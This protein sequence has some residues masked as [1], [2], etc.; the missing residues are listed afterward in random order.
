MNQKDPKSSKSN[1][2]HNL[3][4]FIFRLR[5]LF[6]ICWGC[7]SKF[8][9]KYNSLCKKC[10]T[11]LQIAKENHG[12]GKAV[13]EGCGADAIQI[14]VLSHVVSNR[15]SEVL[16]CKKCADTVSPSQFTI[17]GSRRLK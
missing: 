6:H 17:L 3:E 11:A 10:D 9:R 14:L 12:C 7:D 5:T 2:E 15:Q 4:Y 1:V 16:S 8:V 13:C